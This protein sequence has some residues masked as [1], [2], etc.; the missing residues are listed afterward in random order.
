MVQN[1]QPPSDDRAPWWLRL[2]E[3]SVYVVPDWQAVARRVD[4]I[5]QRIGFLPG[6]R[7]LDVACGQGSDAVELAARG[8]SVTAV[9]ASP[10]ML[11]WAKKNAEHRHVQVTWACRDMREIAWEAQFDVV[12]IRD[13]IFGI[14]DHQTNTDVLA[15]CLRSLASGGRLFLEVYNKQHALAHGV[16]GSLRYSTETGRFEGQARLGNQSAAESVHVSMDLMS[17]AEWGRLLRSMG[18]VDVAVSGPGGV[19]PEGSRILE[20]TARAPA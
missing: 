2:W 12:M 4:R 13:V 3:Q 20:I 8:A 18:M 14:F 17:P 6:Q 1:V 19:S 5:C 11:S 7:I 10:T 16:E 15:R 9:D